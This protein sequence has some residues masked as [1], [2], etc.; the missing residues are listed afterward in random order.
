MHALQYSNVLPAIS[1]F[2]VTNYH[3]FPPSQ[4]G[5]CAKYPPE[6]S[7]AAATTRWL[8]AAAANSINQ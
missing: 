8:A 2:T 1:H 3:N 5:G 6:K 7:M 4:K